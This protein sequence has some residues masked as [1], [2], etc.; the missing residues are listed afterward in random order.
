MYK[1]GKEQHFL[2]QRDVDHKYRQNFDA[3]LHIMKAAHLLIQISGSATTKYYVEM[4][5]SITDSYLDK[6]LDS[7]DRVEKIWYAN[8]FVCYW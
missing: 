5:Q 8:F 3:V 7:L 2:R 1:V 4:I 6:T